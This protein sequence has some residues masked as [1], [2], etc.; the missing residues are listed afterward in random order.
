M[1]VILESVESLRLKQADCELLRAL[2]CEPEARGRYRLCAEEFGNLIQQVESL[3]Q[4]CPLRSRREQA[5]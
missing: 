1:L 5:A 2:S 3:Q 4:Y